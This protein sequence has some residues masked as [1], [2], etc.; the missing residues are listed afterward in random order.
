MK[1]LT[2]VSLGQSE[3]TGTKS[4]LGWHCLV[5]LGD[6]KRYE[7]QPQSWRMDT[8]QGNSSAVSVA[9]N[10]PGQSC[11]VGWVL[12]L[13]W[14]LL[15][16]SLLPFSCWVGEDPVWL[17]PSSSLAPPLLSRRKSWQCVWELW[18]HPSA[19]MLCNCTRALL[20]RMLSLRTRDRMLLAGITSWV[21]SLQDGAKGKAVQEHRSHFFGSDGPLCLDPRQGEVVPQKVCLGPLQSSG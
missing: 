18:C 9:L 13:R 5:F 12:L 19:F 4:C 20:S 6:A 8:E 10:C 11:R 7:E 14:N 1:H 2:C 16:W 17:R 3:S 15:L 21:T